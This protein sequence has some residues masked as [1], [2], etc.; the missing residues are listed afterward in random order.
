MTTDGDKILGELIA[1]NSRLRKPAGFVAFNRVMG[2]LM[3]RGGVQCLFKLRVVPQSWKVCWKKL[4][5]E[6]GIR[7]R[8]WNSCFAEIG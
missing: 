5:Q 1:P 6:S 7:S 8:A 2:Y 3:I 4:S